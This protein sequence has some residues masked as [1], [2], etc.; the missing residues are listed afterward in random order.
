MMPN[1]TCFLIAYSIVFCLELTRFFV[2]TPWQQLWSVRAVSIFTGLAFLTHSLYLFGR[3]FIAS[4]TN[5]PWRLINTWQDWGILSAW[6]LALAYIFFLVQRSESRIGLFVLPLLISFVAVANA[7][8][9]PS[10]GMEPSASATFWRLIHGI[11]MTVGTMLITLGFAMAI[12]YFVQSWRLKAKLPGRGAFRLPSLEYLQSFGRLCL[13]WSAAFI[14]FGVVSGIIM[15][16]IQDGRIAWTDR[17][18]LVSGGLFVWLVIA[19]IV[20]WQ[21][22]KRGRGELTA[23]VNILS[24]A[25]VIAVLFLVV[26]A[27]HG[28]SPK[29]GG[30]GFMDSQSAQTLFG[31]RP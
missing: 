16:T 12:M 2:K 14:G 20:Q 23:I 17:G 21:S 1:A 4:T 8:S 7:L 10:A 22:T 19:T 29:P 28:T 9:G 18:I 15:N 5:S 13:I 27:P 30:I 24:F 25:I 11:A 31:S 26:S 6:A 3:M